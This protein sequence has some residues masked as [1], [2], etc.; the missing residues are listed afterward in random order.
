[1]GAEANITAGRFPRQGPWLYIRARVR[2]HHVLPELLGTI[3]RDDAEEPHVTIIKLDDG[4]YVLA[5]ECQFSPLIAAGV[6]GPQ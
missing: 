3:V 2:F 4:R 5:T 1:M 6:P